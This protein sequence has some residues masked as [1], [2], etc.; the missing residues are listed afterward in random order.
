MD[1][2]AT[3][4]FTSSEIY[5]AGHYL[6][7]ETRLEDP[8][9]F[10]STLE[11]SRPKPSNHSSPERKGLQ[12]MSLFCKKGNR[13]KEREVTQLMS[14][15]QRGLSSSSWV[16]RSPQLRDEPRAWTQGLCSYSE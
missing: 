3:V 9:S 4:G 10:S 2:R 5:K 1:I 11:S 6:G 8:L 14:S 16:L 13:A 15:S 12:K 7:A